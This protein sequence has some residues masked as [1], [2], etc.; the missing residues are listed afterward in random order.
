MKG[1]NGPKEG[2][3][4][5]SRQVSG[6]VNS[7]LQSWHGCCSSPGGQ[8]SGSAALEGVGAAAADGRAAIR[9]AGAHTQ[10]TGQRDQDPDRPGSH[11]RHLTEG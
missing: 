8:L 3:Q 1:T 5:I 6:T 10:D 2:S 4:I 7:Y 11:E 9:P